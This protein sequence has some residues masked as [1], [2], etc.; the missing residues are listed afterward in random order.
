M[1]KKNNSRLSIRDLKRVAEDIK[2][3]IIK[4]AFLTKSQHIGSSL[5]IS[6]LM[7]VLYFRTLN[8]DPLKPKK[9]DRDR[10]IL[11]KG[12]AALGLYATLAH[13]G[14]FTYNYLLK[15]FNV[16]GGKFGTHPDM[17]VL[18]GIE[19]SSG[20]LGYGL[21][22]GAGMALAAKINR[23]N[24]NVYVIIGDGE[25]NEGII[26]ETAL[27]AAHN[28][29]NNLIVIID[30]N[31]WQAFGRTKDVM[32]LEPFRDKWLAFNWAVYEIDGHNIK[33]IVKNLDKL[34][35]SPDKPS[36]I[37]AHTKKGKGIPFLE[38]TLESHYHCLSKEEMEKIISGYN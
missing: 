20:S 37:I 1:E 26:W 31:G 6:D 23:E 33:E 38:D 7:T 13:R 16:D 14:F 9:T 21:S 3:T 8:I 18:A 15:N 27:F 10:F 36:I 2:R 11:S 22:I 28:R 5:S 32:N 35:L 29:L 17:D 25:C 4:T 24:Y 34:P 30:Y 12:H 19:S